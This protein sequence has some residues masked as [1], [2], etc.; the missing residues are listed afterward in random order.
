[1]Q[2]TGGSVSFERKFQPEQY[3]SKGAKVEISFSMA[4]G[5]DLGNKLDA[6]GDMVKSKA[7]QLCNLKV[8]VAAV[9]PPADV[10]DAEAHKAKMAVATAE[11]SV[12]LD[13]DAAVKAASAKAENLVKARAAKAAKAA[14][15]LGEEPADGSIPAGLSRANAKPETVP[16][17]D[18][19]DLESFDE[20]AAEAQ[21]EI[22]DTDLSTAMNRKVAELKPKH[23]GAAPKLI[24]DL[25]NT[26]VEPP[27]KSHDIPQNLRAQFLTKLKALV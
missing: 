27:K 4:E 24:K 8:E 21:P 15:V 20:D 6:V 25:I 7:L 12:A 17:T 16:D 13:K 22:T 14:S 3:G 26:F 5:E 19:E 23:Q 11:A 10:T 18:V 1:M 9:T 2:I